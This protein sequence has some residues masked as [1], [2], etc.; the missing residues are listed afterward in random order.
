MESEEREDPTYP[1]ALGRT[2]RVY[3]AARD[4]GRKDLADAAEL[5]YS[6][7]AEI[8]KGTKYPSTKALQ[9][10]AQA[11]G[12][13]PAELLTATETLEAPEGDALP[14]EGVRMIG[15]LLPAGEVREGIR[16]R[17]QRWFHA[18]RP[19]SP[20][21]AS[22]PA[23]DELRFEHDWDPKLD[24]LLAELRGLLRELPPADR[25]R[26]LDLARRLARS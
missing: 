7:L 22:A 19:V 24:K 9:Q 4:M 21:L 15:S 8:E 14:A 10:I 3:R 17:Q 26:V 23:Q 6:Y 11:L 20:R 25:Q 2:I 13:T 12:L 5:S 16:V 1:A 18:D